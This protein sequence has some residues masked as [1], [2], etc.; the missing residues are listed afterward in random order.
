MYVVEV[1]AAG[2]SE[3]S[4]P[5]S[6]LYFDVATGE[7]SRTTAVRVGPTGPLQSEESYASYQTFGGMRFPTLVTTVAN[8]QALT[9]TYDHLE[10]N[11]KLDASRVTLQS[12]KP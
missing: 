4:L 12:Q 3:G 9:I 1:R 7:L 10:V 8:S 2:S 5:E 11:P 6:T